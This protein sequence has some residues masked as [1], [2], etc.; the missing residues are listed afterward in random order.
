MGGASECSVELVEESESKPS[1]K[2]R[3]EENEGRRGDEGEAE[4]DV[5]S[6]SASFSFEKP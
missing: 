4:G 6:S 1:G 3:G 2:Q 5:D